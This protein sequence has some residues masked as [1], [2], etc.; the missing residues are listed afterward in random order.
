[1]RFLAALLRECRRYRTC[2]P[3]GLQPAALNTQSQ[4]SKIQEHK[5]RFAQVR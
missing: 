5:S 4:S 1:M 3:V 2:D